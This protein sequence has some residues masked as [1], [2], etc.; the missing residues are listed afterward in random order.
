M[1]FSDKEIKMIREELNS[2]IN[3]PDLMDYRKWYIEKRQNSFQAH[4]EHVW[5]LAI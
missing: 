3:D 5:T 1:H 2:T 4:F